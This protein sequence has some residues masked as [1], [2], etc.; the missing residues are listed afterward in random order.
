MPQ[1]LYL[2][3]T[4]ADGSPVECDLALSLLPYEAEHDTLLQRIRRAH[5][6][7]HLRTDPNGLARLDIPTYE[8]LLKLVPAPSR[9]VSLTSER[10]PTL[11]VSAHD[12]DGHTGAFTEDI[13]R[14]TGA[15]RITTPNSIYR[16]GDPI[17][18]QIA[19]VESSLPLTVQIL[20][21]TLHGDLPLATRE[22]SLI[23]GH[24]SLSVTSDE[25]YS[26]SVFIEVIA[27]SPKASEPTR[28]GNYNGSNDPHVT[29]TS[30]VVLFPRDNS[31]K[32]GI[33]MSSETFAPGDQASASMKVTGPQDQDGDNR[34]QAPSALGIVA[35]DQA[36]EERNRTDTD[37]GEANPQPFFFQWR[38]AFDDNSAAGGFTLQSVERLDLAK[39]LPT[40]A[41]ARRRD[42]A[43]EPPAS[44]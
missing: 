5:L 10:Q 29:V 32:V 37:F 26:G 14:P 1:Q 3:A 24:A 6:L 31:L 41:P 15:F 42:S 21:H 27:M 20:R 18:I 19:A 44:D 23:N 13:P 25:R 9:P 8:E 30:H 12:K 38:S 36:V 2:A 35:V 4:T 11:F 7:Q 16:P 39:P 43:C 34:T 40:G 28:Y 33:R 22:V 17:D